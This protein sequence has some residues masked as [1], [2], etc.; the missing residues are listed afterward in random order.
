MARFLWPIGDLTYR[1]PLFL[2]LDCDTNKS[3]CRLVSNIKYLVKD[4]GI[5]M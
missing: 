3:S 4:V 5:Y 2:A 1:D